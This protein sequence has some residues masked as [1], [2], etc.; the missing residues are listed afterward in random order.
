MIDW[1]RFLL[2]MFYAPV[3]GMRG[4]RDRGSLAP[5]A[6]IAFLGQLAYAVITK[7]FAGIPTIGSGGG[8]YPELFE[9]AKFVFL[10]AIVLVPALWALRR[11]APAPAGE[12]VIKAGP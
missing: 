7:R 3:R 1:L 12:G 4:M 2:M 11:N 6:V 10:V 9:A 8:I 5:V